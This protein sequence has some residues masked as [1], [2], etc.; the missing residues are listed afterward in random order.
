MSLYC[1]SENKFNF[2]AQNKFRHEHEEDEEEE[3]QVFEIF[4]ETTQ[5]EVGVT[6]D[7]IF[8]IYS[9][10]D[11]KKDLNEKN[12]GVLT[13]A[14]IASGLSEL[15]SNL[16]RLWSLSKLELTNKDLQ[17]VRILRSYNH[18]TCIDMSSNKITNI[19]FLKHTPRVQH[20]SLAHNNIAKLTVSPEGLM[21][22]K[23]LDLSFNQ[24]S[25]IPD[26][27]SQQF[28]FLK[29][30]NLSNN[31][32]RK[33]NGLDFTNLR[34]LRILNLSYNRLKRLENLTNLNIR[35]LYVQHNEINEYVTGDNGLA[36]NKH[37]I[38]IDISY[39]HLSTLELFNSALPFRKINAA[40]NKI[41]NLTEILHLQHLQKL[42]DL[43]L[44]CNPISSW[45][46][47]K[48]YVRS[49]AKHL[50]RHDGEF[51]SVLDADFHFKPHREF[52]DEY[53][54]AHR[55]N[56]K[57]LNNFILTEHTLRN[58]LILGTNNNILIILIGTPGCYLEE[59]CTAM[60]CQFPNI[61]VLNKITT[62]PIK[63]K[64][65]INV[66][67]KKLQAF[68]KRGDFI[69]LVEEYGF[70]YGYRREGIQKCFQDH[71]ICLTDMDL[72]GALSVKAFGLDPYLI[73]VTMSSENDH[74]NNLNKNFELVARD[75]Q[76]VK[77][78][79]VKAN[80]LKIESPKSHEDFEQDGLIPNV[81]SSEIFHNNTF[82]QIAFC[83]ELSKWRVKNQIEGENKEKEVMSFCDDESLFALSEHAEL[84]WITNNGEL[85]AHE[86]T[87]K[88]AR[89]I[90][91]KDVLRRSELYEEL[92]N[93]RRELFYSSVKLRDFSD[94]LNKFKILFHSIL[95]THGQRKLTNP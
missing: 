39:N 11:I 20:L 74:R 93:E 18:L 17:D 54:E 62:N 58:G 29:H 8:P 5:E 31:F 52:W 1:E 50:S 55:K 7:D 67:N 63:S 61:H 44:S 14:I 40:R 68:N 73:L 42:R 78:T 85:S 34:Y 81:D 22:L 65:Y 13:H 57:A 4:D 66:S 45:C 32:I 94:G 30:L 15:K 51:I 33:V 87:L 83:N 24:I 72:K 53:M 3:Q 12:K 9:L 27:Y 36:S 79:R 75:W 92:Y 48:E 26:E 91:F 37:L 84:L 69:A 89:E 49:I 59:I 70:M 2:I 16:G 23:V 95:K 64:N 90:F 46:L 88:N 19:Q 6:R 25:H 38:I 43:N 77:L 56:I 71:K 76:T 82:D 35:E 60:A 28:H 21:Y 80:E 10:A 41:E 47:Y 86:E